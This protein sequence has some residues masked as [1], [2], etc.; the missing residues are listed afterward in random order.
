[1]TRCLL[2]WFAVLTCSPLVSVRLATAQQSAPLQPSSVLETLGSGPSTVTPRSLRS[3]VREDVFSAE[4]GEERDWFGRSVGISGNTI[5]VGAPDEDSAAIGVNGD[6][7]DDSLGNAGAAYVF[8]K[9]PGGWEQQ[10]YL[11]A[12]NTG[13][14]DEFGATVAV[15]GDTVV[16]SAIREDSSATTVNGNQGNDDL[17]DSGA[18]YVFREQGGLWAQEA[19]LKGSRA[20]SSDRLGTSL[21]MDGDTIVA[22]VPNKD[23]GG[24]VYVFVR[25]RAGWEEQAFLLQPAPTDRGSFGDQVAIHGDTLAVGETAAN[26]RAGSVF[27]YQRRGSTWNLVEALT[28]SNADPGDHFVF[29]LAPTAG[30]LA[31]GAPEERGQSGGLNGNGGDNSMM[32]AGAVYLFERRPGGWVQTDY[33]K[34]AQP[35]ALEAFGTYVGLSE[36]LLF[37]GRRDD[38]AFSTY[39]SLNVTWFERTRGRWR[40]SAEVLSSVDGQLVTD[41]ELLVVGDQMDVFFFPQPGRV[42]VF[43]LPPSSVG[44]SLLAPCGPGQTT[45]RFSPS[46]PESY[47]AGVAQMGGMLQGS[48]DLATTG[49]LAAW[50]FAFESPARIALGGGQ[51]LLCMDLG[52]G[53]LFTGNGIGP[54]FGPLASFALAVPIDSSLCGQTVYTQAL[55]LLGPPFELSNAQDLLIGF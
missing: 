10:A 49:H 31:V 46:N 43:R 26:G 20:G 39:N 33:V 14:G 2:V 25:N 37:V 40:Q 55:H 27:L 13:R 24:G 5:V 32:Q 36:D 50:F 7:K 54:V 8:V 45:S 35:R 51:E 21:A 28:A 19:Y 23:G 12:S 15:F 29:S 17:G 41:G 22:G 52:R 47:T 30:R 18:L 11:K 34:D 44:A 16:I 9:R 6:A 53:E 48:C 1:M 3:L 42:Q 38:F 4:C